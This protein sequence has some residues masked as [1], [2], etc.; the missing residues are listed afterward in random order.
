MCRYVL[1]NTKQVNNLII[2]SFKIKS[3]FSNKLEISSLFENLDF[4]Y[5][6]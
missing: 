3:W 6:K 2:L 5:K 1:I 4:I